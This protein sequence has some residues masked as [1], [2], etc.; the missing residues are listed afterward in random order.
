MVPILSDRPIPTNKFTILGATSRAV[1]V[2]SGV[3]QGSILGSL[4]FLLY[5][6]HLSNVVRNSKIATFADDTKI[7]KTISSNSDASALQNDL[8]NFEKNSTN[9]NL[10]LNPNECK[11]LRVNRKRNTI[12][13][14][15]KL[16]HTILQ[17]TDCERD[18]GIL[19]SSGLTRSKHIDFF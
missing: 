6:N 18:L 14:P 15:Y 19:T 5:E 7:F 11:V 1:P 13:Y 10:A 2:T 4:L 3:P 17:S 8:T 16:K 12:V 9:S